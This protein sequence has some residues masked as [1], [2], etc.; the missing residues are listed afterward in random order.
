MEITN[1]ME[2]WKQPPNEYFNKRSHEFGGERILS[3]YV[4][5]RDGTLL[6][7]DIHIPGLKVDKTAFP[8][9][10]IFTPYYR[11]F[12]LRSGSRENIDPCPTIAFYRD[13]FVPRGYVLA[14]VDIRGSGASFG[15]RYGFRSPQE[16]LDSFDIADWV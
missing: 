5:V 14:C 6:A 15:C 1:S 10:L 9:I 8:A 2:T 11:R 13:I 16:R 7:V 4:A 3:Q 12:A